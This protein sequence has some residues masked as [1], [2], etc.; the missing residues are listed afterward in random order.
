MVHGNPRL[1]GISQSVARQTLLQQSRKWL[2]STALTVIAL[3]SLAIFLLSLSPPDMSPPQKIILTMCRDITSSDHR[4]RSDFGIQLGAPGK[5]FAVHARLRDMPPGRLYV[6]KLKD[7]VAKIVVWRDDDIFRNLKSAYPVFSDVTQERII[8]DT[9]GNVLGTDRWGY[10][11][12]GE[13]WRYVKFSSGDAMGYEPAARK[14]ADQLDQ[15]VHSACFSRDEV[16]R[17][18]D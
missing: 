10:L 7:S 9:A 1:R 13:R 5:D 4:I 6:I 2:V 11:H 8:Q 17:K 18:P 16:P 12:G 15:V 3:F 14:Q